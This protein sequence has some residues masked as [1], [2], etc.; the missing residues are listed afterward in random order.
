MTDGRPDNVFISG[1][2]ASLN[3]TERRRR[4]YGSATAFDG[5]GFTTEVTFLAGSEP[6]APFAG[7]EAAS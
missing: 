2:G 3:W 4:F 1:S 7:P 6:F 5:S